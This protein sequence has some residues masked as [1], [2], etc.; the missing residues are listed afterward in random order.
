MTSCVKN[1][2]N[3][4]SPGSCD[5][6]VI[7]LQQRT[8]CRMAISQASTF[9]PTKQPPVLAKA[10]FG[11]GRSWQPWLLLLTG[12]RKCRFGPRSHGKVQRREE[13]CFDP[14]TIAEICGNPGQEGNFKNILEKPIYPRNT[15]EKWAYIFSSS[16]QN[17]QVKREGNGVQLG[18]SAFNLS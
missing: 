11:H 4:F 13:V 7:H 1:N 2:P 16:L 15:L 12:F 3:W 8:T 9:P 10:A 14:R 17:S 18:H 5:T 6:L